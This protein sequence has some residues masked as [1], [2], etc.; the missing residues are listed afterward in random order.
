[1]IISEQE[2]Y[3]QQNHNRE[4]PPQQVN[5]RT[6]FAQQSRQSELALRQFTGCQRI[7]ST[8]SL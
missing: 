2:V 1:M 8:A 4:D 6:T 3:Y 7:V 5:L